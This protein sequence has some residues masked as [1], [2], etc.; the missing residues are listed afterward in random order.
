MIVI[1]KLWS[2]GAKI[3]GQFFFLKYKRLVTKVCH[4]HDCFTHFFN[5]CPPAPLSVS[6]VH[7]RRNRGA[8]GALASPMLGKEG[9]APQ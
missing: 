7:G 9:Q 2:F 6:T 3:N 8:M 4:F 1:G 5:L